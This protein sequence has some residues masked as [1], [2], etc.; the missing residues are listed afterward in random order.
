[1]KNPFHNKMQNTEPHQLSWHL[2]I[3]DPRGI[4]IKIHRS[5]NL[6]I[7]WGYR[8][9]WSRIPSRS[10][11][12]ISLGRWRSWV[13]IPLAPY[14]IW[15]HIHELDFS[16]CYIL[17]KHG[18]YC[19]IKQLPIYSCYLDCLECSICISKMRSISILD[20]GLFNN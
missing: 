8:L 15:V 10:R 2:W 18:S 11:R 6:R 12:G 3:I 16:R 4:K 20:E 5:I 19:T 13:Q 17:W 1:M 14:Y 7:T 9:A